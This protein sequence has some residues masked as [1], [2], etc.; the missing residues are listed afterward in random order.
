MGS[1]I[2]LMRSSFIPERKHGSDS[3]RLLTSNSDDKDN[4]DNNEDEAESSSKPVSKDKTLWCRLD[5]TKEYYTKLNG[6]VFI[7]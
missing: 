2:D 5:D 4:Y 1:L 7:G 3:A 6:K